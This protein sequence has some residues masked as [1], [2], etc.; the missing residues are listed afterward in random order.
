MPE[1]RLHNSIKVQRAKHDLTQEQ[2]AD[3]I[4]V[5]RK[6]I[7]T[8]ETGKYVP[9]TVLALRLARVFRISVEELFQL[10]ETEKE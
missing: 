7:N 2:L 1:S 3:R 9:S 4:G 10:D 8:I 6:T 5:T